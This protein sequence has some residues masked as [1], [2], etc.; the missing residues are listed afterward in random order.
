MAQRIIDVAGLG[1]VIFNKR[2]GGR[3]LRVT[4]TG[5]GQIR[6]SV[7]SWLPY[8]AGVEFAKHN[9]AWIDDKMSARPD[10]TLKN[11][12]QIGKSH[13]LYFIAKSGDTK[14]RLKG[15]EIIVSGSL[16]TTSPKV[17]KIASAAAEKALKKEAEVLLAQRLKQLSQK[18]Q[19]PYSDYRIRKMTSR[20]GHCSSKGVITLSYLLM[21]LPWHLIDYVLVHELVHTKEMNHGP[22]FWA[23]FQSIEPKAKL[24]RKEIRQ[25][26]P[27][28]M[29]F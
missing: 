3:N 24:L 1:P 6:V 28:L 2:R 5:K 26:Q 18:H 29:V 17:Q 27:H 23:L 9:K 10:K 25:A 19:L 7:P 4:I 13:R 14:A 21:Q 8:R 15:T 22:K 20:W 12:M 11:G 16:P